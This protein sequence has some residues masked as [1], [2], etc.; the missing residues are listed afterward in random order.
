MMSMT[1]LA[2]ASQASAY[3]SKDNYYTSDTPAEGIEKASWYGKGSSVLE[4]DDKEFDADK[5]KELL[6]G[7]VDENKT[8]GKV[9]YDEEGNQKFQH[10]PGVDLTFSAP[11]SVSILSEVFKDDEV[12]NAHEEA[13]KS[14]LDYVEKNYAKTRISVDGEMQKVDTENLIVALFSHNNSRELDPQTHTHA[15]VMNATLNQKG[16]WSALS[17]E[18]IYKNQKLIGAIYNSELANNLNDLGYDL[19]FKANG[20]FEIAGIGQ[21]AIDE[22]SQ[23]RKAMIESAEARGIDLSTASAA[24][25]EQVALK[26]RKSKKDVTQE[27]LDKDW[28]NRAE[29]LGLTKD[30]V[31]KLKADAELKRSELVPERNSEK[32]PDKNKIVP[33][34]SNVKSADSEKDLFDILTSTD[35][36]DLRLEPRNTEVDHKATPS[37]NIENDDQSEDSSAWRRW[38]DRLWNR[39]GN[40]NKSDAQLDKNNVSQGKSTEVLTEKEKSVR[41]SVFYAIGHHTEREMMVSKS[42]VMATAL[43]HG[44]ANFRQNDVHEEF[45][46]LFKEGILVDGKNGLITTKRL[47][48]SE[49]WSIDHVKAESFSV[50]RILS[51]ADAEKA[52]DQ[53]EQIQKFSYTPGQRN[54]L[55]GIFTQ[56]SRYYAVDGL[57]GVGKTTMLNG[58]NKIASDNGFI[59]KGMAEGGVAAKNLEEETGIPSSTVALFKLNEQKLQNSINLAGGVDRKN[60]IWVVDESSF[61]GQESLNEILKLSKNANARVVFLGDKLQ[62][63]S[64]AAGKPFELLQDQMAKS[65]MQDINRQKTDELKEVVS[66]ITAKDKKGNITLSENQKAF[67]LLDK[68]GRIE[69]HEQHELH[70]KMVEAYMSNTLEKRNNTLIITPF[71]SD[72]ELIN[73]LVREQRKSKGELEGEA[74]THTVYHNKNLTK[75]QQTNIKEYQNGDVIRF[76]K[77][78]QVDDRTKLEKDN[79]YKVVGS[80]KQNDGKKEDG[81]ILSGED[82]KTIHWNAKNKNQIEVYSLKEREL[83][84]GD[85]IKINRSNKD[86]K[87][88]EKYTF[89][90]VRGNDVVLK[91]EKGEEKIMNQKDFKHWDHGYANTIYSSQGLT[92]QSVFM[93]INSEKLSNAKHDE[94]AVKNL[95]K[96]FGNRA[97]YV[98]VTRASQDLKIFTHDKNVARGAVGYE[99][100]KTS[101]VQD[102]KELGNND[103]QF[104]Q[105]GF[106]MDI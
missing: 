22:F 18:Q 97:F 50:D 40:S 106:E 70:E 15:V 26:S 95:G 98:G 82:G 103:K 4:L 100:D 80:Y 9:V 94:K 8:I 104:N 14:T 101:Y 85:L 28:S 61:S 78:Y 91:N 54:A 12:R 73:N 66:V 49:I 33:E 25:R 71:N 77:T 37:S 64:I 74:E 90:E 24:L 21:D 53:R 65:E 89:H 35:D 38:L 76:N 59:V 11:K 6:S 36:H 17:N 67:D 86:F 43:Y 102:T 84:K 56:N 92:K 5:F 7:E 27:S 42:E 41:E 1:T 87:N 62:L 83:M 93:L 44:G 20:N 79:Y 16:E 39:G 99:Q 30:Y 96:I 52:I 69:Q 75:A 10:R 31:E 105:K 51:K 57:A 19:E 88:G 63:Q 48:K 81:L 68:Q 47:A 3:Y 45:N 34:N 23:R 55:K 2:S 46:R 72:R 29:N 13:V 60:E 32:V 58:L